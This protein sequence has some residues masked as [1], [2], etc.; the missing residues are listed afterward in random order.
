MRTQDCRQLKIKKVKKR[1]TGFAAETEERRSTLERHT[2]CWRSHKKIF[3]L[4]DQC[5]VWQPTHKSS[6]VWRNRFS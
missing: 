3:S 1:P 4:G 2:S 6:E 5:D